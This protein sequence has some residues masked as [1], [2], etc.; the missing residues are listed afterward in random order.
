MDVDITEPGRLIAAL[1]HLFTYTPPA[2]D[3]WQ[4]AVSD[5]RA[6]VPDLA[7]ELKERIDQRHAT[8]LTFKEAFSDFYDTC[9]TSIN[10][11]LSQDAVEEDA[12]PTHP[13]GTDLPDGF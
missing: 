6:H 13:H 4:T 3:N 12:H 11:E 8:D 10:P 1:Q 9:R 7:N 2:L 5:F